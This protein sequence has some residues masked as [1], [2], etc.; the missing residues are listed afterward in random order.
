MDYERALVGMARAKPSTKSEVA[1]S[2]KCTEWCAPKVLDTADIVRDAI[3]RQLSVKTV[4]IATGR[5]HLPPG[6]E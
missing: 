3:L 2:S 6:R 5:E 4:R 1:R